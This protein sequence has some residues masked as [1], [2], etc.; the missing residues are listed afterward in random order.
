MSFTGG[1]GD[2]L[3]QIMTLA[4]TV[5]GDVDDYVVAQVSLPVPRIGTE[6]ERATIFEILWVDWYM[7]IEDFADI[8]GTQFA[9]LS[10]TNLGRNSGD[11]TSLAAIVADI[12]NPRSFGSAVSTILTTT[13]GAAARNY[14]IHLD[15]TDNNGNGLLVAT[16]KLFVVAGNVSGTAASTYTAKV[17][18]RLVN[19]G[20]ME[21]VG[22]VQSQMS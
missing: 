20:T 3:P 16:D 6:R 17:G 5:A 13:S 7:G 10:T 19:V 18:Y 12:V 15:L 1:T 4:T 14:P 8:T 22:I 2:I 21:Y 11:T 9:H